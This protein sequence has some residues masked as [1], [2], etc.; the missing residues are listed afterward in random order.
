M[1]RL[2]ELIYETASRGEGVSPKPSLPGRPLHNSVI[3]AKAGI[4]KCF[5]SLRLYD[6]NPFHSHPNLTPQGGG[7]FA[8]V[9][10]GEGVLSPDLA[11]QCEDLLW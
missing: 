6:V 2:V 8:K 4:Q 9:S 11:A 10:R 1:I 3:P 5:Y 7:G